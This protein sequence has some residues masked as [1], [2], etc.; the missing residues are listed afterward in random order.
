[1]EYVFAVNATWDDQVTNAPHLA[2]KGAKAVIGFPADGRALYDA[3][4]GGA[5]A[6]IK[7]AKGPFSFGPGEM[8]VVAR[9]AQPIGGVQVQTPVVF[10]DLSAASAP[11]RVTLAASVVE[12]MSSVK[13]HSP[14]PRIRASANCTVA[15][16]SA[17][18]D[19][20]ASISGQVL[21]PAE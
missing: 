20:V 18:A 4:R 12:E 16:S 3:V 19:P 21:A 15:R 6:E 7:G 11:I 1:M 9:T 8:R 14:L 5:V 10:R 13:M 17:A 2:I